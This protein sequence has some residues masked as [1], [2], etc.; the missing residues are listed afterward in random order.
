M[1]NET[2]AHGK[3]LAGRGGST[4]TLASDNGWMLLVYIVR[5]EPQIRDV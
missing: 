1:A 2:E 3:R 4:L 5:I